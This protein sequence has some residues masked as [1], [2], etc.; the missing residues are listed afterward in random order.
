MARKRKS[1]PAP[2]LHAE[3]PTAANAANTRSLEADFDRLRKD[4]HIK[5]N[6]PYGQQL[7]PTRTRESLEDRL[8]GTYKFIWF[9]NRE[10]LDEAINEYLKHLP[11]VPSTRRYDPDWKI[12]ELLYTLEPLAAREKELSRT[13]RAQRRK[14]TNDIDSAPEDDLA[15]PSPSQGRGRGLQNAFR[16]SKPA[17][18]PP[19]LSSLQTPSLP[20]RS[21]APERAPVRKPLVQTT[22]QMPNVL[23]V[24]FKST[25]EGNPSFNKTSFWSDAPGTQRTVDTAA[26]SFS[27]DHP[28]ESTTYGSVL[29]SERAIGILQQLESSQKTDTT[30]KL[31]VRAKSD[32]TLL[33]R[34]SEF[35]CSIDTLFADEI[36]ARA[37]IL[38]AENERRDTIMTV[39]E[40]EGE[41]LDA[42]ADAQTRITTV[43]AA[44][45]NHDGPCKRQRLTMVDEPSEAGLVQMTLPRQF[46]K[47]TFHMQWEVKRVLQTGA[48]SPEILSAE[49]TPRTMEALYELVAERRIHLERP[50]R[51]DTK[52]GIL[53]HG[54]VYTRKAKLEWSK[55]GPALTLVPQ[56]P[57]KD[58][59]G[60]LERKFGADRVLYVEMP[61]LAKPPA[62]SKSRNLHTLFENWIM[63]PQAFLGRM[64][65]LLLLKP[66]KKNNTSESRLST[67]IATLIFVSPPDG[68]SI[69]DV[70][71]WY[72]PYATNKH[73]QARKAY[74]RLEL[75]MS[76]TIDIATLKPE[77]FAYR[78]QD[79][80]A[81]NDPDDRRFEDARLRHHFYEQYDQRTVMSDGCNRMSPWIAM[82][83]ASIMGLDKIPPVLQIRVAGSKGLWYIDRETESN[84]LF[85]G[86]PR[87]PLIHLADSQVKVF[88]DTLKGCDEE[89][90]T[91]GVVKA[92]M[93]ARPSILHM[94]FLP[95]LVD[96]G[97]SLESIRELVTS[98]VSEE[99]QGFLQALEA[100]GTLPFRQW[101]A[102]RQHWFESIRRDAGIETLA[103][104][105]KCTEESIIQM[106][107]SGF[108]P[109]EN[110]FL[111]RDVKMLAAH[112]F[113]LK[114]RNFQIKLPTSTTLWGIADPEDC[115][116]PG[117][118]CV[119]LGGWFDGQPLRMDQREVL[120]ARNP[121][122]APWDIQK[123]RCVDKPQLARFTNMIIFSAKGM[124]PLA[125]KLQGGDYDG[126]PY[127][128]TWEDKLVIGFK[129]APA[130][131]TPPPPEKFG[132]RKDRTLLSDHVQNPNDD[133]QWINWLGNMAL[134]RLSTNMLG[135]V[136]LF[137]ER[138]LYNGCTAG[139]EEA[140]NIV[141]LHDYL[142][143]SDKQ[144]YDYD[145]TSFDEYKKSTS[146]SRRFPN[147]R[148][149]TYW[150]ITRYTP[151]DDHKP[152]GRE[153]VIGDGQLTDNVI[154]IIF[155]EVAEPII[156]RTLERAYIMLKDA[157]EYDEELARFYNQTIESYQSGAKAHKEL[158]RLRQKLQGVQTEWINTN[159]SKHNRGSVRENRIQQIRDKYDA[160][161]PEDPTSVIAVEWLRRQ[162]QDLTTWEKLKASA[163]ASIY[164]IK[165]TLQF[166][167]AGGELC[168]LKAN[169]QTESRRVQVESQYR[170]LKVRKP[171]TAWSPDQSFDNAEGSE[172]GVVDTGYY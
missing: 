34:E 103:G 114:N 125:N 140:V 117:E 84:S 94:L 58:V 109:K 23:G 111:A 6:N 155:F 122:L 78:V 68:M 163:F 3:N 79:K 170:A 149:P 118:V 115:L 5:V 159:W 72:L 85:K 147:L 91:V 157:P 95:I 51:P 8:C 66:A 49:W 151:G 21:S 135:I 31:S 25:T 59:S 43:N 83:F 77:D 99:L 80:F 160:I 70:V 19:K 56:V 29:S 61:S 171:K 130:P 148:N 97:V 139:D 124:R 145:I 161:Q 18:A 110:A 50:P 22:I 156:K 133:Q 81:T 167:I 54:Q 108:N 35:N 69:G 87:G 7:S 92:N 40:D 39:V 33:S 42:N 53:K 82:Q 129:N 143:D 75:P 112:F 134:K 100:P 142:V 153:G 166:R 44:I 10:K 24:S 26:T 71:Q 2:V 32:A 137:H 36:Q 96:R 132:I 12:K 152:A 113:D 30:E 45:Y 47:L 64:W 55:T 150:Q 57:Q 165:A 116:E 98:Q 126:D 104:F 162:G 67:S 93:A 121:A 16:A 15:P 138:L 38:S 28:T 27:E 65:N 60:S 172:E 119:N 102:A 120:V 41:E 13:P 168:Y 144:G 20:P 154:D 105:A 63:T 131:W 48:I 1:S 86:K 127:W 146:I 76:R 123:V 52:A 17:M 128:I 164:G 169:E 90:L 158:L 89:T 73:Q 11:S 14:D 74:M 62:S 141:H 136:T 46:Q 88:R 9:K 4:A 37:D 106:L 101:L 107:E